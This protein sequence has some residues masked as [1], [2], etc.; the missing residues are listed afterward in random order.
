MVVLK[1]PDS[2][3]VGCLAA[4]H[5]P[6]AEQLQWFSSTASPALSGDWA[7]NCISLGVIIYI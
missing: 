5:C 4:R 7:W 2:G 1:Q 3:D 6:L